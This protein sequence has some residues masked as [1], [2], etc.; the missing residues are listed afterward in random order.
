MNDSDRL[1][2]ALTQIYPVWDEDT[3]DE[4]IAIATSFADPYLAILRDDLHILL[5]QIDSSGDVDEVLLGDEF[6]NQKWLSCC[7]YRDN[8]GK[9]F[10][11]EADEKD[12]FLLFLLSSDSKLYVSKP[13]R[14][15]LHVVAIPDKTPGIP[16]SRS[17]III[18]RRRD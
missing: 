6:T 11:G 13:E 16:T 18:R 9:F 10:P 2:L 7:L 3:S 17:K 14:P 5:L 4:R 1:G 12:K 8:M 15:G